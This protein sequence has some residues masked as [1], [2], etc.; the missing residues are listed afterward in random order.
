MYLLGEGIAVI[1]EIHE[2]SPTTSVPSGV[3]NRIALVLKVAKLAAKREKRAAAAASAA[4]PAHN[5]AYSPGLMLILILITLFSERSRTA[6]IPLLSC[7]RAGN[8]TA[9]M[10]GR[11][12]YVVKLHVGL[13]FIA[14]QCR[15][16][17][18][19]WL[20]HQLVTGHGNRIAWQQNPV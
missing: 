10:C 5:S 2:K 17:Y 18:I 3:D 19:H 15:S 9:D 20:H 11:S 6:C 8:R 7:I 16:R 4:V 1:K 14:T 12:L 13:S